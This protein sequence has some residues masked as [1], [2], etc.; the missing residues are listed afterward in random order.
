MTFLVFELVREL[1]SSLFDLTVSDEE[2]FFITM[3]LDFNPKNIFQ[4]NFCLYP[5]IL[6]NTESKI[7]I[8][9]I[10]LH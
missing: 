5:S 4:R 2:I 8:L 3:T 1:H 7:E 10:K 9:S 6:L